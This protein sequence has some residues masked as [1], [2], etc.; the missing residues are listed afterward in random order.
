MSGVAV[1]LASGLDDFLGILTSRSKFAEAVNLDW[2][3]SREDA[4]APAEACVSRRLRRDRP[5]QLAEVSCGAS[6]T[7]MKACEGDDQ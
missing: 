2:R 1:M 5:R 4:D 6:P 7:S 3:R